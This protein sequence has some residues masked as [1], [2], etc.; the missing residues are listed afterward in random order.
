MPGFAGP[1]GWHAQ[2]QDWHITYRHGQTVAGCV[3]AI[4][5]QITEAGGAITDLFGRRLGYNQREV[6]NRNGVVASNGVAHTKIIESLKP[7]LVQFGRQP[8]E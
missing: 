5:S 2:G 8:V 4:V 3:D 7:L 1:V 6:Q